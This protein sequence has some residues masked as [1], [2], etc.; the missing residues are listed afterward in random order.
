MFIFNRRNFTA[1]FILLLIEIGIALFIRDKIIRPYIGDVLVVILIYY[2]T[3]SFL[4]APIRKTALGVL[5]FAYLIETL[6]Y[7]NI[8]KVLG[9]AEYKIANVVIGTHFSWVDMLAYTVGIIIV[10]LIETKPRTHYFT[11]LN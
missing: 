9:L 4:D 10:L 7:F 3:K 5:L 6:Q 8:V 2:F 11:K 1:A